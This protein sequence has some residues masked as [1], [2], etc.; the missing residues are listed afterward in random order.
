MSTTETQPEPEVHEQ[1]ERIEGLIQQI[2]QSMD[3]A[4]RDAARDMVRALLDLHGAGLARVL[5]LLAEAGEPGRAILD[6]AAGDELLAHLLLLHGLHPKGLEARV[7]RALDSVRPYME[8]HGGNVE[9]LSASEDGVRLRMEGSCDGC[10]SS[11]ATLKFAIEDAIYKAAPDVA[12]IEV[13]G[14]VEPPPTASEIVELGLPKNGQSGQAVPGS[15]GDNGNGKG[16]WKEVEG[17]DSLPDGSTRAMEVGERP[18]LFCR[19]GETF[20][21]YGN[22]CPACEQTLHEGRLKSEVLT[23]PA[24]GRRYDAERAGRGVD[25]PD[26]HLEPL[27]LLAEQGRV[28]V[29]LPH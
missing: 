16:K 29:A 18:I 14:V 25:R 7:R 10:P 11:S 8:S 9:L 15:A 12:G 26:L 17:L 6:A 22:R 13:E 2:E 3:S 28:K 21:A 19:L 20:Y 27:P 4:A 1:I 23:C 5:D 24:C